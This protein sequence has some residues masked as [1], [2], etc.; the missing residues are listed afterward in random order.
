[1][2]FNHRSRSFF[3]VV[4]LAIIIGISRKEGLGNFGAAKQYINN[5]IGRFDI[6]GGGPPEKEKKGTTETKNSREETA[7]SAEEATEEAGN[8]EPKEE[9]MTNNVYYYY[10]TLDDEQKKIYR[11]VL[12]SLK[13]RTGQQI[14]TVDTTV[15]TRIYSGVMADHPEIFY[16]SGVKYTITSVNGEQKFLE[17]EPRY[18]MEE[19][20]IIT[21]QDAAWDVVKTIIAAVPGDADDYTKVKTVYDYIVANTD[22]VEGANENQNIL[23]VLLRHKSVCN[24]YAKTTELLLQCLGIPACLIT[25]DAEGTAHAWNLVKVSGDWYLLDVTWGESNRTDAEIAESGDFIRYDYFLLPDRWMN[26]DHTSNGFVPL[27]DCT[28]TDENYFVRN[29]YYIKNPDTSELGPRI[30]DALEKNLPAVQF[31]AADKTILNDLQ[32]NLFD[33]QEIYNYLGDRT[34]IQYS[35]NEKENVLTLIF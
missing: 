8:D 21:Y 13:H 24:G 16:T 26:A 30:Q 35:V 3:I 23:S 29:G 20:S 9:P 27:P 32:K 15:L 22:Y 1:M 17:I 12:Y 2:F 10:T 4:L 34:T 28:A 11:Q 31:R 25:G 7:Q 14:S 6:S 33:K 18:T 19:S 5:T